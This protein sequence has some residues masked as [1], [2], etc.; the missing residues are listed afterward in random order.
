MFIHFVPFRIH[1]T[2]NKGLWDTNGVHLFRCVVSGA[3]TA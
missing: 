3:A 2:P 1:I